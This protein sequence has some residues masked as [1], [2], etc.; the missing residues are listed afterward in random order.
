MDIK[1]QAIPD[2]PVE[3]FLLKDQAANYLRDLIVTGRIA[4]GSKITERDVADLLHISRMPARDA[5]ME[6]ERLG[7]VVTRPGGRYVIKLDEKDIRRLSQLRMALEKLAVELASQNATPAGIAA[8]EAK[9]D[10]MRRAIA[11]GNT[12]QY[13][14]SDLEMHEIIWQQSDNPYL[15]EMLNA[16]IGPIFMFIA[17]Q[18]T[19]SEDWEESLRL[20]E[21]LVTRI[22][23]KD[24]RAAVQSIEAHLQHSLELSLRTFKSVAGADGE[25]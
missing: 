20:H 18:A 25:P 19:I 21:Q 5:L 7:L 14:S 24:G 10:E 17:S 3:R 4:Q 11:E 16:M 6:L 8:C 15:V 9:L 12:A 1:S 2:M 22:S 13:S 23:A